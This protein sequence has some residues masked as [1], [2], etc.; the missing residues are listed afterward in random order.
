MYIIVEVCGE[1]FLDEE[2]VGVVVDA[3]GCAFRDDFGKILYMLEFEWNV[4]WDFV[5]VVEFVCGED[6]LLMKCVVVC[7]CIV[8]DDVDIFM[9]LL[10]SFMRDAET[11]VCVFVVWCLIYGD[12]LMLCDGDVFFS[13][14]LVCVVL[15]GLFVDGGVF[16][17][18]VRED[19]CIIIVRFARREF[20]VWLLMFKDVDVL[21]V[22]EVEVWVEMLEMWMLLEIVCE[23]V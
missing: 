19:A 5:D 4:L 16:K 14:V 22:I 21:V 15:R 12:Y 20:C 11:D 6:V 8:C 2:L 13:E 3:F 23:C 9:E 1:M 10:E 18:F 7:L 17:V